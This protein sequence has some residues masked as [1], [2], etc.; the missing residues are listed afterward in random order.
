MPGIIS[1]SVFNLTIAKGFCLFKPLGA[2]SF[3]HLGNAPKVVYTPDVKILPHFSEM[4]GTKVQDFSAILQKGG[5]M[6]VDMEERTAF[7]LSLFFLGDVNSTDPDAVSVNIYSQLAQIQGEFQFWATNDVGPRWMMDLTNVLISPTNTFNTISDEY[8]AMTVT[9]THIIGDD[10]LWGS[11]TKLPDVST[12]VPLNVLPPY[13]TGP[14]HEGDVPAYAQV[15]ET[16][17]ANIGAWIGASTGIAYQWYAA[18]SLIVGAT[19][20]TYVPIMG[21]I[22][23]VLTVK[24]TATNPVGS[25]MVTSGPTL[26][27]HG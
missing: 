21:Q 18:A 19:S 16:M 2:S 1:P 27:V 10:G 7:N 8:A 3:T 23:E 24:V 6:D 11:L 4:Q 22:G 25:A 15:G 12:V 13:I 17:Q 9:M 14:L 5:K 26:P 20:K